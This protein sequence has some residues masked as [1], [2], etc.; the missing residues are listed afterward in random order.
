MTELGGALQTRTPRAA[1]IGFLHDLIRLPTVVDALGECQR[2][3]AV[4]WRQQSLE[5]EAPVCAD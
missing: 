1:E 4:F 5:T 2:Y 3:A